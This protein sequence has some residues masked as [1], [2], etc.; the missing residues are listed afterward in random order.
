MRYK[1]NINK[2]YA[3]F[4]ELIKKKIFFSFYRFRLFNIK[5]NMSVNKS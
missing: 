3:N 4:G 2:F 1:N 5:N